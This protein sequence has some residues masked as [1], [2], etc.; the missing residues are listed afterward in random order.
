MAIFQKLTLTTALTS[1]FFIIFVNLVNHADSTTYTVI[2]Q[3]GNKADI[4]SNG[5]GTICAIHLQIQDTESLWSNR[6]DVKDSSTFILTYYTYTFQITDDLGEPNG[7]RL[8][9]FSCARDSTRFVFASD[10]RSFN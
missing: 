7:I 8:G 4:I 5:A 2:L 3:T 6:Q 9:V 1:I 10:E